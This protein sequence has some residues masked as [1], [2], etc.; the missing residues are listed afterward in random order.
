M[1]V[2]LAGMMADLDLGPGRWRR[3]DNRAAELVAAQMTLRTARE[4]T[5]VAPVAGPP[6]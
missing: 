4:L 1:T 2:D 6:G 3:I 5:E